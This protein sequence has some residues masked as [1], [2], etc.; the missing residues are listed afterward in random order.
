MAARR[1]HVGIDHLTVVP[2]PA[3]A[4]DGNDDGEDG[5]RTETHDR[6]A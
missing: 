4:G 1:H 3:P 5:S 2:A 6:D